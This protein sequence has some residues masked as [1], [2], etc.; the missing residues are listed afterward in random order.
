[1]IKARQFSYT[2]P[3]NIEFDD[4]I[5]SVEE[6]YSISE[7]QPI[8]RQEQYL[9]TF[10]WS[11]YQKNMVIKR[12]GGTYF[13]SNFDGNVIFEAKG[14]RK[15]Y[16]FWWD[17]PEGSLQEKLRDL[18]HIRAL[19]P[20]L[21]IKKN[22]R[23]V[24]ILNKDNKTV[25]RLNL[26]WGYAETDDAEKGEL[27]PVISGREVRGYQ[28][29]FN[30]IVELLNTSG[31]KEIPDDTPQLLR[32]LN[33]VKRKPVDYSSKFF[34]TLDVE[35]RIH[36]AVSAIC[37]QLLAGMKTNLPGVLQDVDSE[38]LHDFRIAVRRTR[39][40]LS[41]LK[42]VL[43]TEKIAHFN[44]EFRW[45][46]SITG[47]VRDLDV[48]LLKKDDFQA[49]L[50]EQLHSGLL[51]FMQ[52]LGSMRKKELRNMQRGL[53]SDRIK[54]LFQDWEMFLI[55]SPGESW[56]GAEKYCRKIAV[57]VINKRF[58]RILR[59][60]VAIVDDTPNEALHKLRI[61]GKKL[62]YLIEFFRSFFPD[63]EV[64]V[65]LKQMKKLQNNLGDFNDLSVQQDMLCQYQEGLTGRSKRTVM[66][67]SALGGLIAHLNDE[68]KSVR[69]K[70]KKTFTNFSHTANIVLFE[71]TFK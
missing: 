60:G 12:N 63:Q 6:F 5:K 70:F 11:L 64:D 37:L 16:P 46:G 71:N 21:Q 51:A 34:I 43:P 45:L 48:Y 1:M 4:L 9:D 15:K 56:T 52:T 33:A 68:H 67:A 65:F 35:Y 38:F 20:L 13:L 24:R 54:K 39:S 62:R 57:K 32:G 19:M 66:V 40:L 55:S 53:R 36:E 59:D 42:K 10:D 17:L 44:N 8:Q 14:T 18:T 22:V 29:P 25:L 61:Q 30:R 49:M 69:R 58:R 47:P 23:Q 41:Q 2:L 3:Q 31:C 26:E 27:T 7:E 28:K 50:P